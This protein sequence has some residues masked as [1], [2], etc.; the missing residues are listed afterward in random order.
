LCGSKKRLDVH[1]LTYANLGKESI[2]DLRVLCRSCHDKVHSLLRKY[3][4]LKEQ[5]NAKQWFIVWTRIRGT[6]PAPSRQEFINRFGICRKVL[7]SM[8]LIKTERM[9]WRDELAKHKVRYSVPIIALQQYIKITGLDPRYRQARNGA[10][11][12]LTFQTPAPRKSGRAFYFGK[13]RGAGPRQVAPVAE[14]GLGPVR[15]TPLAISVRLRASR[16]FLFQRLY[17]LGPIQKSRAG[18]TWK[19]APGVSGDSQK[20]PR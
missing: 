1:H 14:E 7:A 16:P 19:G 3:P 4:K 17:S 9:S 2:N 8:R 6:N 15:M 13:S 10:Q 11:K 5:H 12:L 20:K 18:C